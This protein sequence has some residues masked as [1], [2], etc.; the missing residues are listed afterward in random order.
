MDIKEQVAVSLLQVLGQ[1]HQFRFIVNN[2]SNHIPYEIRH[3]LRSRKS[4]GVLNLLELCLIDRDVF[5]TSVTLMIIEWNLQFAPKLR[6]ARFCS[7]EFWVS[8]TVVKSQEIIL[9]KIPQIERYKFISFIDSFAAILN[10]LSV[11]LHVHLIKLCNRN[12]GI[13]ASLARLFFLDPQ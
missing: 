9:R 6:E 5:S 7:F 11:N 3:F 10:H 13:F 8:H 1:F 2:Y 4:N 12:K